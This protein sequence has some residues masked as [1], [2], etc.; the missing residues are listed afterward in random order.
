MSLTNAQYNAIMRT[1][2][3]KRN[4]ALREADERT[5][6]IYE[7]IPAYEDLD[8]MVATV[9]VAQGRKILDGDPEASAELAS[10]LADIKKRKEELLIKA[11]Y[12]V[13]YLLPKFECPD[14]EDTGKIG[15]EKC[16]CFKQA[17]AALLYEQSNI[18]TLLLTE[19]FDNLSYLYYKGEELPLFQKAVDESHAFVDNFDT[20]YRNLLF[21]G[22]VGT[23]KSFL[24]S[25]IAKELL[26]AGKTVLYF[27]SSQLFEILAHNSFDKNKKEDYST[28]VEDIM[29]CDLLIIDDLGTELTNSFVMT[30]LFSLLTTRNLAHK[31]TIISTN[32]R[33]EEIRDRYSDRIYSR[34]T[35]QFTVCKLMGSDIRLQKKLQTSRK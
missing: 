1:Y 35:S 3:E 11:G 2:D 15:N 8:H 26:N 7:Q 12:P 19:N 4:R 6:E 28:C 21:Y 29:S 5:E 14:C 17:I 20:D 32:L 18:E 10:I 30:Q 33:L 25:C 24:S 13:D 16:H 27:S 34:I 22:T 9:S 23:G 31:S